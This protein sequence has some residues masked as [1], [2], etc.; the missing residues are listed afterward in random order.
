MPAIRYLDIITQRGQKTEQ[1]YPHSTP[2]QSSVSTDSLLP[3]LDPGDPLY[4]DNN[5]ILQIKWQL[6]TILCTPDWLTITRN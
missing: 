1:F 3:T 2:S 5:A 6:A 4:F